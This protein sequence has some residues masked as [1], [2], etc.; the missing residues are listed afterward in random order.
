MVFVLFF[1][2]AG[3]PI[4]VANNALL[5]NVCLLAPTAMQARGLLLDDREYNSLLEGLVGRVRDID[6]GVV[7]A[8]VEALGHMY[9]AAPD[10]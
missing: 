10:R 4:P 9:R 5:Y 1:A 8:A 3:T 7:V 2:N 6:D